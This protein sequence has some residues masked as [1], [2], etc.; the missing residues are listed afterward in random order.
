MHKT[1]TPYEQYQLAILHKGANNVPTRKRTHDEI[2]VIDST[3]PKRFT[4]YDPPSSETSMPVD[5]APE[6]VSELSVIDGAT[7]KNQRRVRPVVTRLSQFRLFQMA[8]KPGNETGMR[9]QP[10]GITQQLI[11]DDDNWEPQKGK[12]KAKRNARQNDDAII[13]PFDYAQFA[14]NQRNERMCV[15]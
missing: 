15:F 12:K 14:Q 1:I 5:I 3:T 4:H 2:S 8:R 7:P 13:S 6:P 9:Q 10:R 11:G